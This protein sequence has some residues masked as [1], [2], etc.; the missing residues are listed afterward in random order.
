MPEQTRES[1]A[2]LSLPEN[3]SLDWLRKQAKRQLEQL[4]K[5]N[6]KAKLAEGQFEVAKQY[7]FSSWRALKA[8]IDSLTIDGQ[9]IEA[10][11]T[12]DIAALTSVLYQNPEKLY[13]RIP[14]YEWTL[15]HTAA[16]NGQLAAVDL[17]LK[18]GLDVNTREKGDN[19]YAMHWAATAGH[20]DVV[21]RLTDAGGDVV[22]HGDDHD[23][24]V[25]GWAIGW[26]G[27]DDPAHRAVADF[28][29]SRGARHHIFSAIAADLPNEVRRIVI[30]DPR[31]LSRR[32]SRNENHQTPLHYAVQRKRK[33]IVALLLELGAD[34]LAVDGS[35]FPAAVYA[36]E[37]DVDR[38]VM[39]RI[40]TML[41]AELESAWRGHRDSRIEMMDLVAALA[42][43]DWE[44][45]A[46]LVREHRELM[47]RGA[48][49]MMAK[50]NDVTAAKWLLDQG[51]DQNARWAHWD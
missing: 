18:R 45:A 47:N 9:L 44:L 22:G 16:H 43:G 11:R 36:T 21:K 41:A 46:R 48:L 14:P 12:G 13:L 31:V 38:P 10:A 42:L 34:P 17:L 40:R 8:H 32:M 5:T 39:E 27:C 20:L 49:H 3:P 24:E 26:D 33:E 2:P 7:G 29:S 15:L 23:L 51:A 6:P 25:I 1:S 4:Q 28:L 30:E 19:T 50:R 37:P 35:G